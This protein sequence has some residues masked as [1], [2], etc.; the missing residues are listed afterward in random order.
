M[1]QHIACQNPH[2]EKCDNNLLTKGK[3]DPCWF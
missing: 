1:L 3:N 2:P